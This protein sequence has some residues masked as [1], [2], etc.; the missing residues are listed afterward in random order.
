MTLSKTFVAK[1]VKRRITIP[2]K[3]C[4]VLDVWENDKIRVTV[5]KVEGGEKT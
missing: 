5:E 1:I 3:V 4:D 2:E